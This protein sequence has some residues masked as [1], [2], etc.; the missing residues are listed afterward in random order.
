MKLALVG[1]MEYF[2]C[3]FENDLD[4]LYSVRS[5]QLMFGVGED[6][7][8]D[9]LEFDPDITFVFRGELMPASVIE[10]L[11]GITVAYSTEPIPNIIDGSLNYTKDSLTRFRS[12]LETFDR[13]Y[14][15]VFHYDATAEPFLKTIGVTLSGFNALPIACGTYRTLGQKKSRDILFLGRSSEHREKILGPLKRDFDV[16]HL[17]H[18]WPG[19][20]RQD[21][22]ALLRFVDLFKVV[23][24]IHAENE[25]SWE[26][27]VQQMLACA[28]LVVSE[29]IS[30]NSILQ[31]GKH[32]L[33]VSGTEEFYETCSKIIK[34]PAP[35]EKIR[36]AGNREV[37]RQLNAKVWF[38]KLF[39]DIQR[40][41][42]K[43]AEFSRTDLDLA[44]L[45][46]ALDLRGFDHLKS[47]MMD[48]S[49][50]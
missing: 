11:N 44:P 31:P 16:V 17:S 23:L 28:A 14:D 49:H 19:D 6:Y 25:I 10:K 37:E 48:R 46:L 50:A 15:Y 40:G 5:F 20:V 39:H 8:S 4:Q 34:D 7:S 26:P 32:F 43:K 45:E 12:F 47:W 29:R 36:M 41:A 24:N 18:G 33:E 13:D 35:F 30:P 22:D 38:K 1:Q 21:L 9:L 42:F 2:R 27:R 3:H